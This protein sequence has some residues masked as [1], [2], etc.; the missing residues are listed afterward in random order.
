M[1]FGAETC[2]RDVLVPDFSFRAG[3]ET[4]LDESIDSFPISEASRESLKK[5]YARRENVFAGKPEDEVDGAKAWLGASLQFLG[6]FAGAERHYRK[7]L[8]QAP[9]FADAH[10]NLGKLLQG[11]GRSGEAEQHFR[12]AM[13]AAPGHVE[14]L[15]GLAAWLDNQGRY[16]EALELLEQSPG[17][18][19]SYQLAPIHARVLRHLGKAAEARRLLERVAGRDSLPADARIQLHF[20]LAAVADEQGDYGSAWQHAVEANEARRKLLPPGAPEADRYSFG[21]GNIVPI[22]SNFSSLKSR[23]PN[24]SA[25]SPAMSPFRTNGCNHSPPIGH[26]SFQPPRKPPSWR[27]SASSTGWTF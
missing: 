18:S 17:M 7:A 22:C 6:D 11:Q 5:F 4:D 16:E 14:A 21:V 15:S 10:A 9:D 19:G 8:Q 1:F 27:T 20:S 26:R 23:W 25:M 2:G 24:R 13:R 12:Q 3:R